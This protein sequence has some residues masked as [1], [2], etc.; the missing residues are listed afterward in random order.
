M[1][2]SY[3]DYFEATLQRCPDK[4]AI[5]EEGVKYDFKTTAENA[6]KLATAIIGK[7][8]ETRNEPIAVFMK[9]SANTAFSDIG[10]LYSANAFMNLD[11]KT[12]KERIHNI[13]KQVQP[14][15][16]ISRKDIYLDADNNGI[17]ADW[18]DIEDVLNS[19]TD[20]GISDYIKSIMSLTISKSLIS[21]PEIF[22]PHSSS[23]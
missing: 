17:D 12:P 5:V 20:E 4:T 3:I 11:I 13:L 18:I 22:F 1:Y 16:I 9:K 21:S 7:V 10:I 15:L 19:K 6:R 8:G 23:K 14:Q 2:T